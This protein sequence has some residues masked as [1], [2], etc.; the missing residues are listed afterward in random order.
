MADNC[1][2][3]G[4]EDLVSEHKQIGSETLANVRVV[5]VEP[6]HP[7]NIGGA[8]RA[9]KN[10][11]LNRLAL[12]NPAR[13][14]DPQAQWRAAGA[15][16]VLESAEVFDTV[17]AAI[18][19]CQLVIGTSTRMRRIPW[20]SGS[21]EEVAADVLNRGGLQ[22][23]V[24]FGRETSGLTNEELQ[25][26][27]THLQI[28][29]APEYPSLNLAMAVQVVCYELRK[30]TAAHEAAIEGPQS[31]GWDRPPATA[32]Q[33]EGFMEHLRS[34]LEVSGFLDPDNPGQTLTRLRRLF[35]R[36]QPDATELQMLRG[37]LTQIEGLV[38]GTG[39]QG[40]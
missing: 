4:K 6:S 37:V 29:T 1:R 10:M 3:I 27:H 19:D 38:G 12:V 15:Q 22:V 26:C 21:A 40:E 17:Q 16:D 20:P 32:A 28:P 23:A 31:P 35:V 9:M 7:G 34:A 30:Q 14:P 2:A 11:G 39:S 36:A 5:L 24:L 33:L 18:S 25:L 8:A 13:F